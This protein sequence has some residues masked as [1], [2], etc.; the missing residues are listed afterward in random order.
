MTD[1]SFAF[2]YNG[3]GPERL[4]RV[5]VAQAEILGLK[6]LT[7]SQVK[8]LITEGL[9]TVD[10]ITATKAGQMVDLDSEIEVEVVLRQEDWRYEYDF[11]LSILYEDDSVVVVDKPAGLTVHPAPGH[12]QDTLVNALQ[13]H[14]RKAGFDSTNLPRAGIVHRLDKDTSG[15]LVV[16][17]TLRAHQLLSAAFEKRTIVRKYQAFAYCL[18]RWN[19]GIAV[20][21]EG[22]IEGNLMRDP[23]NRKSM[24][25]VSDGGKEARTHW[26]VLERFEYGVQLELKL[27]TGRTHQIRV[28]LTE[29][30][31]PLIG[32]PVYRKELSL[33]Q[34]IES[35]IELERQALHAGYLEFLHPE[36]GSAVICESPLPEDLIELKA[37]LQRLRA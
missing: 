11:P 31:F 28:H 9:I 22:T 7:R 27:D 4:D 35:A 33:P 25:Q 37:T 12:T 24:K 36:N 21:E 10:G 34:E 26:R 30:G 1:T 13:S 16:A 29:A 3:K 14:Y 23:N 19:S 8:R 20:K 2:E 6:E 18:P 15:A 17:K 5:V 32:D